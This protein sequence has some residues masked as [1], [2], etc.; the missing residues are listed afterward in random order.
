MTVFSFILFSSGATIVTRRGE[1]DSG[2]I[3]VEALAVGEERRRTWGRRQWLGGQW[4][5]GCRKGG[6]DVGA[7]LA[8][9]HR[10]LGSSRTGHRCHGLGSS[11]TGVQLQ[12]QDRILP[13][14]CALPSIVRSRSYT[15]LMLL[16][17]ADARVGDG[18]SIHEARATNGRE[19]MDLT[20]MIE[21][22]TA[23]IWIK[24]WVNFTKLQEPKS[25]KGC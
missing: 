5:C 2:S 1:G 22:W 8:R 24:F 23:M 6:C 13:Q 15:S 9:R 18:D 17:G 19:D 16:V 20:A 10:S 25:V 14:L 11:R 4:W 7:G 12:W 3:L 21:N